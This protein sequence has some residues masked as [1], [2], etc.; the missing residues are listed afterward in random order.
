MFGSGSGIKHSGS[1][2]RKEDVDLIFKNHFSKSWYAVRLASI[3]AYIGTTLIL[4]LRDDR[5][6]DNKKMQ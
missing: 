4:L 6:D 5:H 1:A 2:T 3:N